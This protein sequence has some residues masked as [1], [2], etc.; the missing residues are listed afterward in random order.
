MFIKKELIPG[1][2]VISAVFMAAALVPI[3][4]FFV[5]I[6]TPL[7]VLYFSKSNRIQGVIAFAVS[8]IAV[9]IVLKLMDV[10]GDLPFM[11]CWGSVGIF[12]SEFLKKKYSLD[13]A[14]FYSALAF[15]A[16]G[17]ILLMSYSLQVG[18][19]PWALV[20]TYITQGV[21]EGIQA[22]SQA[23]LA[24]EQ[25]SRIRSQA[26]D[27]VG[28]VYRLVPAIMVISAVFFVWLNVMAAKALFSW[29]KAA[30]PDTGDLALWKIPDQLVWFVIASGALMLIP[31]ESFKIAGLNLVSIFLFVYFF[32]GLSIIHFYFEKKH[33]SYFLR[34]IFYVLIFAQHF[35]LLTVV[36]LGFFDLWMDFR[37]INSETKLSEE[38]GETP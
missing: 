9:M 33:L 4:G 31:T 34:S 29:R 26:S 23:G 1:I 6:F 27:I 7:A 8:V 17:S 20:E 5:A 35:V 14:V 22:Y 30:F 16:M 36:G 3:L 10:E 24:P 15:L 19:D 25:I 21:Q 18:E 28:T 38:K 11:F 2:I 12:L 13:K 32:Q 37:K